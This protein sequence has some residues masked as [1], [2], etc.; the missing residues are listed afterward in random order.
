MSDKPEMGV[1]A[2][3]LE[4]SGDPQAKQASA[5]GGM[6]GERTGE[7]DGSGYPRSAGGI[8][9][10]DTSGAAHVEAAGAPPP[11]R[12]RVPVRANAVPAVGTS[13]VVTALVAG[14]LLLIVRGGGRWRGR[15]QTARPAV[16]GRPARTGRS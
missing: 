8:P 7:A 12:N 5:P 16:R 10:I 1:A 15:L 3:L 13:A 4:G 11:P 14:I 6:R 2:T 9:V